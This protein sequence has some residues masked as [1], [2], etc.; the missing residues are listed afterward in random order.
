MKNRRDFLKS[1]T[2]G[3]LAFPMVG[4]SP[5]AMTILAA[6]PAVVKQPEACETFLVRE[7]T[8]ITFN[9][10]KATDQ[11]APVSLLTEELVVGSVIPMH[12]HLHEDEFFFFIEGTGSIVVDDITFAF[13]PGT[14]AFVPKNT[15]HSI[16]NTGDVKAI[17]SFGY[18][19]AGFEDFFRQIGTPKGQPFKPKPKEEVQ[20]I[21]ETFGMVFK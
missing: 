21:A 3:A 6:N 9:I 20:R 8:P 2:L 5:H 17:F 7:N 1:S 16:K 13:K 10:S 4:I 18:S 19:P 11:V 12:K 14:T 15:W